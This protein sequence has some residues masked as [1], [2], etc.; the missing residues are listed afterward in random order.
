MPKRRLISRPKGATLVQV[1][2]KCKFICNLPK[3]DVLLLD[4]DAAVFAYEHDTN[5]AN[6]GKMD[7]TV[8]W[9]PSEIITAI[10]DVQ[11]DAAPVSVRYLNAAGMSANEPWQGVNIV[12][13]TL[14]DGSQTVTKVM[15]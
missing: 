8:S 11:T 6:A 5:N 9:D 7:V 10:D 14:S 1:E 12:V 15:K 4:A 2:C 13:T 3:R